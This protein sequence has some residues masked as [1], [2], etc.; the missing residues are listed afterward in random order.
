MTIKTIQNIFPTIYGI[1]PNPIQQTSSEIVI[2]KFGTI[3]ATDHNLNALAAFYK[4][5]IT[6]CN[7]II[8]VAESVYCGP[9]HNAIEGSNNLYSARIETVDA[10]VTFERR[11]A[12]EEYNAPDMFNTQARCRYIK[13]SKSSSTLATY[14][15]LPPADIAVRADEDG[16]VMVWSPQS[17]KTTETAE[18]CIIAILCIVALA[19]LLNL[20]K[21]VTGQFKLKE[22]AKTSKAS[23]EKDAKLTH[24]S[25][26]VVADIIVAALWLITAYV[27]TEGAAYLTH[28]AMAAALPQPYVTA[29]GIAKYV[30]I[31]AHAAIASVIM[32]DFADDDIGH[33]D[34]VLLRYT[35]EIALLASIVA[36]IPVHVAPA[37]H[38]MFEATVGG[39]IVH[40]TGR[41]CIPANAKVLAIITIAAHTFDAAPMLI[42]SNAV[43]PGIELITAACIALQLAAAG[44]LA[45]TNQ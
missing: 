20:S 29:I 2:P 39:V 37:F 10:K 42:L 17:N 15:C 9:Q 4:Q 18:A 34:A 7:N 3:I 25:R 12:T 26:I 19:L 13:G 38:A 33:Q 22:K 45:H 31:A 43:P 36:L 23:F 28:P 11:N 6:V 35:A 27:A 16:N 44:I 32:L 24:W 21:H 30:T 41:D 40:I 5:T 1:I 8:F 14:A